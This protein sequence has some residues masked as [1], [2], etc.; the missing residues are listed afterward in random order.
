MKYTVKQARMLAGFTQDE[1]AKKLNIH[2]DTYRNMEKHPEKISFLMGNKI[3]NITQIPIEKIF[4][5]Q[6]N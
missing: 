2:R 3:S 1:M 4:F 6:T 5:L